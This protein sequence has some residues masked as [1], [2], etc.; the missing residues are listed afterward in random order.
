MTARTE[1]RGRLAKQGG[2]SAALVLAALLLIPSTLLAQQAAVTQGGDATQCVELIWMKDYDARSI[3]SITTKVFFNRCSFP[4][5]VVY[6]YD[7]YDCKPGYSNAT[8]SI[9]PGQHYGL[10]GGGSSGRIFYGACRAGEG[11]GFADYSSRHHH[12]KKHACK[13][14][15]TES[16]SEDN[17]VALPRRSGGSGLATFQQAAGQPVTPGLKP[18]GAEIPADDSTRQIFSLLGNVAGAGIAGGTTGAERRQ[19]MRSALDQR[20]AGP[21]SGSAGIADVPELAPSGDADADCAS[22]MRQLQQ[23]FNNAKTRLPSSGARPGLEMQMWLYNQ[24]MAVIKR[25]CPNSPKFQREFSVY[26]QR[27]AEVERT[28]NGVAVDRCVPRLP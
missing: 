3:R 9:A 19:A 14:G 10:A 6:C 18:A 11:Y 8:S 2:A 1:S 17:A 22:A 25:Y 16:A 13:S 12:E 5:E 26:V 7:G 20:G 21:G 28:C 23:Q 15:A 4:V 24:G 27:L